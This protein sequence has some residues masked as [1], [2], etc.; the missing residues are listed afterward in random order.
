MSGYYTTTKGIAEVHQLVRLCAEARPVFTTAMLILYIENNNNNNNNNKHLIIPFDTLFHAPGAYYEEG[1]SQT[2]AS[3]DSDVESSSPILSVEQA[4]LSGAIV[5]FCNKRRCCTFSPT[6]T[7]QVVLDWP[8]FIHPYVEHLGILITP[9]SSPP[10]SLIKQLNSYHRRSSLKTMYVEVCEPYE[11]EHESVTQK[12]P[13]QF[14][15][16]FPN[17]TTVDLRGTPASFLSNIS[18]W[19]CGGTDNLSHI[20]LPKRLPENVTIEKSFL[21]GSG[22]PSLDASLVNFL[23]R[24]S[25]VGSHF[26]CTMQRLTALHLD[27]LNVRELPCMFISECYALTSVELYLPAVTMIREAVLA[28]NPNL[29]SVTFLP[30]SL[31]QVGWIGANFLADCPRLARLSTMTCPRLIA[32]ESN[33][34]ANA[35][36]LPDLDLQIGERLT[37]IDHFFCSGCRNLSDDSMSALLRRC[38]HLE[39]IGSYFVRDCQK[40]YQ[41]DFSQ[42]K[43]LKSIGEELARTSG[44]SRVVLPAS[45]D[46]E[47]TISG[48]F[49]LSGAPVSKILKRKEGG[50]EEDGFGLLFDCLRRGLG[51]VASENL[52]Y[53]MLTDNHLVDLSFKNARDGCIPTVVAFGPSFLINAKHLVT[54]DFT[55]LPQFKEMRSIK[56]DFLSGC[57]SLASIVGLGTLFASVIKIGDKF[58]FGCSSLKSIDLSWLHAT[59]V[60]KQ[61]GHDFLSGC[62]SLSCLEQLP[63]SPS[64]TAFSR[65]T[66]GDGFMSNCISLNSDDVVRLLTSW[67]GDNMT[68]GGSFMHGVPLEHCQAKLVAAGM[69]VPKSIMSV[70]MISHSGAPR[71]IFLPDQNNFIDNHCGLGDCVVNATDRTTVPENFMVRQQGIKT[72]TFRDTDKLTAVKSG[73]MMY[74]N[75]QT[76]MLVG[77]PASACFPIGSDFL[78]HSTV[79][80]V[81]FRFVSPAASD[82]SEGDKRE[83]TINSNFLSSCSELVR[84]E[85]VGPFTAVKSNFLFQ[86]SKLVDV[87]IGPG[88]A[89]SHIGDEFMSGC[90]SLP[91]LPSALKVTQSTG[92]NALANCT[93]LSNHIFDDGT[94]TWPALK[95]IGSHF[96]DGCKN[97]RDN[98]VFPTIRRGTSLPADSIFDSC[99]Y[100]SVQFPLGPPSLCDGFMRGNAAVTTLL[101]LSCWISD[102][103]FETPV[104]FF[105]AASGLK[106]VGTSSP[107]M[108]LQI[109]SNHFLSACV[110]LTDV[111]LTG[112]SGL[113]VVGDNFVADCASLRRVVFHPKQRLNRIG[114]NF[115]L[116]CRQL[117]ALENLGIDEDTVVGEGFLKGCRALP[118]GTVNALLGVENL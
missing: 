50:K 80:S 33:F 56:D 95:F 118:P 16:E 117:A 66:I 57:S 53:Y 9:S 60:V 22:L 81:V 37:Q 72:L 93:S 12:M 107:L 34:V 78:S 106:S 55:H 39:T 46:S 7:A 48:R 31:Q 11:G 90:T 2:S 91:A 14:A 94:S 8:L 40:V 13:E 30:G 62:I 113:K 110:A 86:C 3:Q 26:M 19:F 23:R 42:M 5:S 1:Q 112:L 70:V 38:T 52:G 116:Q 45:N 92:E 28:S 32:I 84:L 115:A 104:G 114:V 73:F 102:D 25:S 54:A 36:A 29:K 96:M 24:A 98:V 75:I 108:R 18:Y 35:T 74:S 87:S 109:I 97:L 4:V 79:Q 111:D 68:I 71:Q 20:I 103:E 100:V 6:A 43:R 65:L 10:Q 69:N 27:L 41:L 83:V 77:V 63:H 17:L 15:A 101:E 85:L 58:L 64:T 61:I 99:P 67:T 47:L 76:L 89:V 49:L 51:S 44:V 21:T 82:S 59:S 88:W 105:E